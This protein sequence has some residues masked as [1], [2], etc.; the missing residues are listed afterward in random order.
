MTLCSSIVTTFGGMAGPEGAAAGDA[1]GAL[2][3]MVLGIMNLFQSKKPDLFSQIKALIEKQQAKAELLGLKE[4]LQSFSAF[5]DAWKA[6]FWRDVNLQDGPEVK[7]LREAAI[8]LEDPDNQ[9]DDLQSLWCQVLET[10]IRVFVEAVKAVPLALDALNKQEISAYHKRNT[11]GLLN[12][13][14]DDDPSGSRAGIPGRGIAPVVQDRGKF[15]Y[16]G[17]NGQFYGADHCTDR[18]QQSNPSFRKIGSGDQ[19]RMSIAV[20]KADRSRAKARLHV[21]AVDG[22]GNLKHGRLTFGRPGAWRNSRTCAW[23][24]APN[25]RTSGRRTARTPTTRSTS[26]RPT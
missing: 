1:L 10:Q 11:A 9:G 2:L 23:R 20:S 5:E 25:A 12:L 3:G 8:W 15:M 26:T 7:N 22:G 24:A 14:L 16:I 18:Y 19:S 4:T 13:G 17:T 21:F 6:G